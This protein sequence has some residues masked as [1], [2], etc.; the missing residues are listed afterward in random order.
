[1]F[2]GMNFLLYQ[3]LWGSPRGVHGFWPI[4]N[5]ILSA[6]QSVRSGSR[7]KTHR[8]SIPPIHSKTQVTQT[9]LYIYI[10][11]IYIGMD[12]RGA[13]TL[14]SSVT[15]PGKSRTADVP[16][17]RI[18]HVWHR[19]GLRSCGE[20]MVAPARRSSRSVVTSGNLEILARETVT[21]SHVGSCFSILYSLVYKK[22]WKITN[23]HG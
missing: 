10:L 15:W 13:I 16:S 6:A 22:L 5:W 18:S 12:H 20:L 8:R 7:V 19:R 1:M 23:I 2:G 3:L 9:D 4:P 11:Y 17:P 21:S 14:W